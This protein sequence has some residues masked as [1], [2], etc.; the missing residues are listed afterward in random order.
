MSQ[1]KFRCNTPLSFS[2]LSLSAAAAAD[3]G[4]A[5]GALQHAA[6]FLRSFPP[7]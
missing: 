7:P 3:K 1:A 6:F 2:A 5:R 4:G